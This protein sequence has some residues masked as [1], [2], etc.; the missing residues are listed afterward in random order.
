MTRG[1][2]VSAVIAF[3]AMTVLAAAP[4]LAGTA[5]GMTTADLALQLAPAAGISLPAHASPQAAVEALGKVGINLGTDLKAPVTEKVLV[6]VG[7]AV[8]VKVAS[9]HPQAAVTPAMS[10]AFIKVIKEELQLAATAAGQSGTSIIHASC[11]GRDSRAARQGTP[12]SPSNI[13]ATAEPCE[14]PGS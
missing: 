12:A 13:N 11:Q 1:S 4:L 14:E 9:S 8:G 2:R 10:S 5:G 3:V 7:Q 6:Q